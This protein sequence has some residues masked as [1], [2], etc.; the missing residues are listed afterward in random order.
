MLGFLVT[1]HIFAGPSGSTS[2][3]ANAVVFFAKG[4][5]NAVHL[6]GIKSFSWYAYT[7]VNIKQRILFQA[8]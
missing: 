5:W 6:F 3:P 8:L 2:D 7:A 1:N 4:K